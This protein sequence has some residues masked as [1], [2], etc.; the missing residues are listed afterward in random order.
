MSIE[1]KELDGGP[2]V[3]NSFRANTAEGGPSVMAGNRSSQSPC[4][5]PERLHLPPARPREKC[6]PFGTFFCIGAQ[7]VCISYSRNRIC[8][9]WF[10]CFVAGE[11]PEER[12]KPARTRTCS[13][14]C[15]S[16]S[17]RCC[18]W[19]LFLHDT[20]RI[21]LA[22]VILPFLGAVDYACVSR[23]PYNY[24]GHRARSLSSQL[25]WFLPDNDFSFFHVMYVSAFTWYPTVF[26]WRT[27]KQQWVLKKLLLKTFR[28]NL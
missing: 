17:S 3:W 23:R 18:C 26:H 6:L 24:P 11:T 19:S 27:G 8:T 2:T 1:R 22:A 20:L 14:M 10:G 15:S 12:R 25:H 13:R 16:S 21:P 4:T 5:P 9:A 28:T 7:F